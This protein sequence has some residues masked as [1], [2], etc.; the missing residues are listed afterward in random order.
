MYWGPETT[1]LADERYAPDRAAESLEDPLAAVQMGLIYV[2]PEGPAANP[3]PALSALDIRVTFGRMGMDDE[4]TVALIAGGHTFGKTHG[5][6]PADAPG[7]DPEAA[8]L[9][10]QGLG[11][12]SSYKSGKGI[13]AITS[14]LEVTWTYH[15]TRWDNEFFHI[16]YAYE[17]ELFD[18][19]AGAHQ[20]RPKDGGGADLVP[21]ADFSGKREPR[22]LT[23]DLAL[24]VDPIYDE[25]SRRFKDDQDAFA[26]AFARAWF[27]LT[28]RDMGPK[29]RY[30][31]PEVPAEDLICRT[32]S[33]SPPRP[34]PRR[35]SPPRRRRS[36][37]PA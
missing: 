2:N 4:E 29:A 23:S 19:P 26:E 11:W 27:K 9:E 8:P 22:M 37:P 12:K 31:G 17:W 3:D 13:D 32:R 1:W 25:I 33:R 15:P 16:L 36:S 35:T 10:E 24:R 34:R 20:W 7:P 28:H 30:L 5:N 21:E 6:A 14:G 18:S